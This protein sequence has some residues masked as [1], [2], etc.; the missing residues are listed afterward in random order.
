MLAPP[1]SEVEFE[2]LLHRHRLVQTIGCWEVSKDKVWVAYKRRAS[3]FIVHH[4]FGFQYSVFFFNELLS[5][6]Y[7][8]IFEFIE[9]DCHGRLNMELILML[10]FIL[11]NVTQH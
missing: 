10:M 7:V 6:K 5:S 8:I 11:Q 4:D 1:P 2:G 3:Y 9:I